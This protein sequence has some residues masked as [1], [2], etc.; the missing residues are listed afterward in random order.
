MITKLSSKGM[1]LIEVIVSVL[2]LSIGSLMVFSA[3]LAGTRIYKEAKTVEIQTESGSNQIE[4]K[5][6]IFVD[7]GSLNYTI[8]GLQIIIPG[9]FN[10]VGEGVTEITE[11]VISS[12]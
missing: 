3:L 5:Q 1:T 10:Q 4:N 7:S 8:N 6:G 12:K 2:L 11:F 9:T